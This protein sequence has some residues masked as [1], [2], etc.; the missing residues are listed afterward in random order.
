MHYYGGKTVLEVHRL[1]PT[2]ANGALVV[3]ER[4]HDPWYDER[5]KDIV[6]FADGPEDMASKV[7]Q[8]LQL[9]PENHQR[10]AMARMSLLGAK[11]NFTRM[12][13]ES[14]LVQPA[15]CHTR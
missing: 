6:T 3:T 8:I 11:L 5:W 15:P 1:I 9:S 12:A 13:I 7:V 10:L 14:G 4:S 2:V